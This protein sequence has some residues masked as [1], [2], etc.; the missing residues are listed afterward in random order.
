MN[1]DGN[2]VST[3]PPA[4]PLRMSGRGAFYSFSFDLGPDI[5]FVKLSNKLLKKNMAT[6]AA[7]PSRKGHRIGTRLVDTQRHQRDAEKA[8]SDGTEQ[9][10]LPSRP[11]PG[12][13][14][15]VPPSP[16]R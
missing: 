16:R 8:A 11:T 10:A 9:A 1:A 12:L 13:H 14:A 3:P 15:G 2:A 5:D 4:H 6:V 7:S